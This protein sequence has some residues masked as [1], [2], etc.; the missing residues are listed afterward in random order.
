MNPIVLEGLTVR[1]GDRLA[2]DSVSL[3]VTEGSVHAL[4]GRNGAG[5]SSLVRCL[6]G[7]QKPEAGKESP[8]DKEERY[9]VDE[10]A[11]VVTHHQV[12]LEGK[13]LRYTATVGRLPIKRGDGKIEAEMFFVATLKPSPSMSASTRARSQCCSRPS[14]VTQND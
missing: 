4:L 1:Y 6:L 13:T 5:K 10:V 14:T 7:E 3:T 8:G 11:P 2:L 9:D 12:T